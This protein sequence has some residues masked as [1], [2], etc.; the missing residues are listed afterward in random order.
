MAAKFVSERNLKFLLYEVFNADALT[1]YDYYQE[2]N[3][4]AFDMVIKEAIKFSKNLL[5]PVFTEMDRK[6]PELADGKVKVHPSVKTILKEFGKGGWITG[7]MPY[8]LD[9]DQLPHLIAN[10]C[11]FIFAAA[12][13]SASVYPGL[14]AGAT[15]L[16]ESFGSRE[17]FDTYAPSML[18]GK[19]QGTMALTEPEA[20]SSL[21]DITTTAEPTGHGY[22]MIRGQKIF[23]SA[24]DH[25][26]VENVVHLMLGKIK[27]APPGVKGISLFVVPK[28]RL[29]ENGRMIS[30]DVVT[31]GLFHKLGY[32]G[33]PI[34]Q[35]A[36][37]DKNNCRGWLVG[38][39][40]NGLR[41]MFQMMN[42]ARIGVGIG[43]VGIATA[44]YYASLDYAKTRRQGRSIAN[45]DPAL[46]QI[47]II[48]HADVKRM[49]LFQKAVVEGALS[50]IM[51]CSKYVDMT[52]A[53]P[54][55]EKEKYQ[56]LLGI[57][58]PVAK[59]YPSEMGIES[60]SRGLQCFGGSGYCDDYMIEQYYRDARIHPIH[61]GTTGIQGMDLLGRKV[62]AQNGRAFMFFTEEIRNT[63]AIAEKFSELR[64]FARQMD[65]SLTTL[66]NVTRHLMQ[67]FMEK[68]VEYYL[69]DATLYLELFGITAVAWQWLLQGIA[70]RKALENDSDKAEQ[71]FY[72]GKFI[73]LRYFFGYELPKMRGLAERLLNS[74]GLTV[75]MTTELFND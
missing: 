12:N 11:E 21:A 41:Y 72:R 51:Q 45:K 55:G 67:V 9:G 70:A 53:L 59:N 69:S 42:E 58:T 13:Y 43:A 50:L 1:G 63:T 64:P 37:G 65:E 36:I 7:R 75:E 29:D 6:P 24:G 49:L 27:D 40:H 26:G 61:E 17:L 2:H 66:E 30:N 71:T 47:P 48:E 20:G 54:D 23:I 14:S 62:V 5:Y 15:H 28:Y 10:A 52:I 31:S 25:D 68:G 32:R 4:K 33:C 18:S 46:P 74:D 56:L 73:A 19:W 34:V 38:E 22:Y 60:V 39:P 16:I 57:L 3:R 44:A 35:L 8:E